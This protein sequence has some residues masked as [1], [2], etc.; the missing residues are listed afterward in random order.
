M[1]ESPRNTIY[2]SSIT[3]VDQVSSFGDLRSQTLLLKVE[4]SVWDQSR[5]IK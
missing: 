3:V 4:V 5:T 1:P 2:Y